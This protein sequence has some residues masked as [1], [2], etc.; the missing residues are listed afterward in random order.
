MRCCSFH[1]HEKE[2]TNG[3]KINCFLLSFPRMS[4]FL[5]PRCPFLSPLLHQPFPWI[6]DDRHFLR[7]KFWTEVSLH[8]APL[9]LRTPVLPGQPSSQSNTH[10]SCHECVWGAIYDVVLTTGFPGEMRCVRLEW[11]WTRI[12]FW[13]IGS[14]SIKVMSYWH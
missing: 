4:S 2:N 7:P 12:L 10:L 1:D 9:L 6:S 11:C 3:G 8:Q 14:Q 13:W 5:L